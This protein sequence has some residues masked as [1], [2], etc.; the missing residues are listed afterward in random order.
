M[1]EGNRMSTFRAISVFIALVT[2]VLLNLA[3]AQESANTQNA[4]HCVSVSTEQKNDKSRYIFKNNCGVD[5]TVHWCLKGGGDANC[6]EKRL[7][8]HQQREIKANSELTSTSKTFDANYGVVFGACYDRQLIRT[9]TS[10]YFCSM[11]SMLIEA[12]RQCDKLRGC[13]LIDA[14]FQT[15]LPLVDCNGHNQTVTVIGRKGNLIFSSGG[16]TIIK[17]VTS[18]RL[19][20]LN[21]T[22]KE[23]CKLAI[24]DV[25]E[26]A[27][28]SSIDIVKKLIRRVVATEEVVYYFECVENSTPPDGAERCDEETKQ[29]FK[30]NEYPSERIRRARAWA[31]KGINPS[32]GGVRG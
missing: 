19:R 28:D 4:Q 24:E 10:Q 32:A 22:A 21:V 6:E 8:Y 30:M 5:I 16:N 14:G 2:L 17:P 27:W 1:F 15:S 9:T 31:H 11:D 3:S 18:K 7:F 26:S 13:P 29:K 12:E 25:E 23:V 20:N